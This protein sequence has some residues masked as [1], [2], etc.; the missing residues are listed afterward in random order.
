MVGDEHAP[1]LGRP[2]AN[3]VRQNSGDTIAP[4]NTIEQTESCRR[5]VQFMRASLAGKDILQLMNVCGPPQ[6]GKWSKAGSLHVSTQSN[7]VVQL[8]TRAI[9]HRLDTIHQSTATKGA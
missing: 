9:P 2:H 6:V 5:S 7:H 8:Q 4:R 3:P 1:L